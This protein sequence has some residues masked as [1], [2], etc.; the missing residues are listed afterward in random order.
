MVGNFDASVT[1]R[2]CPRTSEIHVHAGRLDGGI[3]DLLGGIQG[4]W[5]NEVLGA[6]NIQRRAQDASVSVNTEV[7]IGVV[8]E[9]GARRI[10]E[11]TRA[12]KSLSRRAEN[13]GG[14]DRRALHRAIDTVTAA[15]RRESPPADSDV[16][17]GSA[18][19]VSPDRDG[20]CPA[21][22]IDLRKNATCRE[23]GRGAVL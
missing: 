23:A 2:E 15:D 16:R 11:L 5:R 20:A 4:M 10:G 9:H 12:S 19:R 17:A 18:E 14:V 13:A 22:A 7:A 6:G 21:G 1:V 3:S 8:G